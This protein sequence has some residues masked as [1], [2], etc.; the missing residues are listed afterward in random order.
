MFVTHLF[1]LASGLYRSGDDASLFLRAERGEA[2]ERTY[3]IVEG[4]PLSTSYGEDVYRTVFPD[5]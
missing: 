1:D 3:R 4:E 2:G 5:G